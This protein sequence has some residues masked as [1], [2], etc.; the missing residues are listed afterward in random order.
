MVEP[1]MAWLS[2]PLERVRASLSKWWAKKISCLTT[3][4]S[5]SKRLRR[6][7]EWRP[8][9]ETREH[10]SSRLN[11]LHTQR[12]S[13][14]TSSFN[15]T[16]HSNRYSSCRL[17]RGRRNRRTKPV[18]PMRESSQ[19]SK[20]QKLLRSLRPRKRRMPRSRRSRKERSTSNRPYKWFNLS[21][22]CKLQLSKRDSRTGRVG[23]WDL[24]G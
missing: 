17:N 7:I 9:T 1:T 20:K 22:L 2:Q 23:I 5:R 18:P 15:P 14:T 24:S 11:Q 4:I 19:R 16:S 6:T 12:M 3:S 10:T 8:I 13:P 21:S